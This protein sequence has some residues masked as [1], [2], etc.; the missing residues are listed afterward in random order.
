MQKYT[1]A[2]STAL[3][4]FSFYVTGWLLEPAVSFEK[5]VMIYDYKQH[6]C[7][8]YESS[9]FGIPLLVPRS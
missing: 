3:L 4:F 9:V 6:S 2:H 5:A 8:S 7:L 1:Q